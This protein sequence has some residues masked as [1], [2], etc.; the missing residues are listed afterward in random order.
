MKIGVL[1][2][3]EFAFGAYGGFGFVARKTANLLKGLGYDVCIIDVEQHSTNTDLLDGIPVHFLKNKKVRLGPIE[4]LRI[5]KNFLRRV[6]IDAIIAISEF[7]CGKWV[8]YFKIAS[9]KIKCLIWVQDIRTDEDWRKIFT[10]PLCRTSEEILPLHI[11]HEKYRR[12]LRRKGVKKS[13]G[14]ITP[15]QLLKLKI[16]KMYKT[17]NVELVPN[18]ISIPREENIDKQDDPLAVFLGR[19]DPIKRPWIYAE[20]ARNFPDVQFLI[21]GVS[22]FPE[23]IN[24]MMERYK[25][26]ENLKFLGLTIGKEK[27]EILSRAWVLINT[28]IYEALPMSFQEALSYKMAILSCQNP[29]AIT[30]DYGSYTGQPFGYGYHEIPRFVKGLQYLLSNSRWKEKGEKG[31]AFIKPFADSRK[32]AERLDQ[33]LRS[34]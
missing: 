9:P 31:Y 27:A 32:T 4:E 23:I 21:L 14:L 6:P 34:L 26:I 1:T 29:D 28:S 25:K 5:A 33:I 13:D 22:H 8:Y 10:V 12:L 17:E 16:K 3:E 11:L 7:A 18:P 20:I 24:P 15:A 19:V 2:G 30:S